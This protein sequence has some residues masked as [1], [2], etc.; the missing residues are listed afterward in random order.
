MDQIAEQFVLSMDI[1]GVCI[2]INKVLIWS[3]G[4]GFDDWAL[5]KETKEQGKIK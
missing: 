2:G 1:D 4:L 5:K 3:D